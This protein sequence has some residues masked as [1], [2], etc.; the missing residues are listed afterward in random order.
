MPPGLE[1]LLLSP[2]EF[3]AQGSLPSQHLQRFPNISQTRVF[4]PRLS[5]YPLNLHVENK[6][7]QVTK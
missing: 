3:L 6:T 7:D 5:E 4:S 2:G 1:N